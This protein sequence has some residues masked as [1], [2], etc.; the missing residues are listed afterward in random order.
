M[1]HKIITSAQMPRK[2]QRAAY[3]SEKDTKENYKKFGIL[4]NS[5]KQ[6]D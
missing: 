6:N 1:A 4:L 3:L 2:G 5:R